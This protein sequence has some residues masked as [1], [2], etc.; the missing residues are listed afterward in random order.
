MRFSRFCFSKEFELLSGRRRRYRFMGIKYFHHAE[1]FVG[2]AQNSDFAQRRK[3]TFDPFYMYIGIFATGAVAYIY[4]KLEHRKAVLHQP[5]PKVGVGFP[6]LF[7]VGRQ[8]EKHKY[9]HD[10]VFAESVDICTHIS[11]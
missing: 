7:G 6:F 8:V 1:L 10:T 2:N 3:K 9:P 11:G 5:L 4:R